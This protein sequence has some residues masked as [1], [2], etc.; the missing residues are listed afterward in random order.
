[1]QRSSREFRVAC[2]LVRNG[3]LRAALLVQ[4]LL[5]LNAYCSIFLLSLYLQVGKASMITAPRFAA[6]P[7]RSA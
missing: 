6:T 7:R 5:Y 2:E 1:M 3:V 4:A